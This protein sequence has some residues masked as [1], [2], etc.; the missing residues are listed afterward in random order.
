MFRCLACVFSCSLSRISAADILPNPQFTKGS[1]MAPFIYM[2]DRWNYTNAD[3]TSTA[4]YVWL[5]LFVHPTDQQVQV[6]WQAEWRLD[7]QSLY[8]F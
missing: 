6:V 4:T 5:P 2:G 7:D 1:K 8:P 3:G